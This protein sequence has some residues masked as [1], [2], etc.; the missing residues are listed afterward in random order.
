MSGHDF[1]Q[2]NDLAYI[3]QHSYSLRAE[4]LRQL[5]E[6][7]ACFFAFYWSIVLR[8]GLGDKWEKLHKALNLSAEKC[9]LQCVLLVNGYSTM[10]FSRSLRFRAGISRYIEQNA[11]IE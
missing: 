5:F 8:E 7:C 1:R 9:F 4:D 3:R 2:F 11:E 6:I 10:I